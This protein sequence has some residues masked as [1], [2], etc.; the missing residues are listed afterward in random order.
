MPKYL[1]PILMLIL[2]TSVFAQ[3]PFRKNNVYGEFLGNGIV[4]SINYERQLKNEPGLGIR[5]GVGY[6]SGNEKFRVSIPLGFNYLFTLNKMKS[7]LDAGISG[8]W[9][10]AAGMKTPKQDT[11]SGGRN[12]RERIWSVVPSIGYRRHTKSQ[13]MW[14]TS[15]TPIFNKYRA[16]PWIGLS[17]GKGF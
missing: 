5:F 12:Y 6:F 2:S 3:S 10:A 11:E 17:I 8:T 13:F 15:F 7:F 16:M 4:A 9:S 1:L 14:R